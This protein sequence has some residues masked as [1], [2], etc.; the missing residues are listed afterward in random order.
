MGAWLQNGGGL[1]LSTGPS[2][3]GG[4]GGPVGV[5]RSQAGVPVGND[6][7]AT[8]AGDSQVERSC[9]S[10]GEGG[11]NKWAS[12]KGGAQPQREKKG[13]RGQVGPIFKFN[14]SNHSN[15]IQPNTGL[16]ELKKIKIKYGWKVVEIR[17]NF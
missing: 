15:L 11:T 8:E 17:N 10:R 16:P 2:Q 5:A 4:E 1:R 7:D 3:G 6:A 9:E 13:E 14:D 12:P